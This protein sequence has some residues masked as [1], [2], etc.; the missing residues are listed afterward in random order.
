M[1]CAVITVCD[2]ATGAV[3]TGG[4]AVTVIDTV[5]G[6]DDTVPSFTVNVNESAP[7]YPA[8]GAYVR[9]APLPESVP[10]EGVLVLYVN[11]LP[12]ASEPERVIVFA[13]SCGVV[14]DWLFA[15]GAVFTGRAGVTMIDTVAGGDETIPSFTVNVNESGPK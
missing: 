5:A 4:A 15:T 7:E 10:C 12:S 8:D 2:A 3:L 6:A 14:T 9:F 11:M 1:S 13:V